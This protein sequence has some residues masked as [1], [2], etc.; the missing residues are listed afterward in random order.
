MTIQPQRA[1]SRTE[2]KPVNAVTEAI[3]GAAMKV[4][5]A[6][7]LGLLES[8]YE[9]CLCH[10]L[11]KSDHSVQR[12]VALP[13][14]YDG[15][16][17]DAGYRIDMLVNDLVVV[18]LKCVERIIGVHEAQILSYLKLSG[19][20]VGLLI[21]FHVRHLRD[22]IRRF[23]QGQEW[24]PQSSVLS[25]PSVVNKEVGHGDGSSS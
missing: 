18:E 22:G 10:E 4:H 7:G 23:V 24:Q 14:A 2:E 6:L 19:K 5:T 11:V 12:Q 20:Q 17:I 9:T 15:I 16:K 21:N 13:V 1:Q 25:V 8:A 3:I